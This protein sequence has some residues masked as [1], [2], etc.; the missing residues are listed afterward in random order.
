M[1]EDIFD[2]NYLFWEMWEYANKYYPTVTNLYCEND[3]W[4]FHWFQNN[5]KMESNEELKE[6]TFDLLKDL[7]TH[8]SNNKN[9]FEELKKIIHCVMINYYC[10]P[11]SSI[12]KSKSKKSLI[13]SFIEKINK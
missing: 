8:K 4:A 7:I 10:E 13:E 5:K 3:E 11:E 12:L 9:S 1:T 2:Y 6:D